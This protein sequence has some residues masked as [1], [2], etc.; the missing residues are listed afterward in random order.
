MHV[1]FIYPEIS[2]E[3]NS[4][5]SF[6]F[7][8][9]SLAACLKKAGHKVNLIH[10]T[11]T[12]EKQDFLLLLKQ[13]CPEG[14]IAFSCTTNDFPFVSRL[15]MWAK[16]AYDLPIICGGVHPTIVPEVAIIC[17][18]IDMICIGE[19]EA[20]LV[21]LCDHLDC[22]RQIFGI[23]N[24][25]LKKDGVIIKNPIRPML[26]ELDSL[27]F[28]DRGV[29][30]YE[31][32]E[33]MSERRLTIMASRG[34][35]YDC[36]YCCNH[37]IKERYPNKAKYVRFRSAENVIAEIEKGLR[38]YPGIERIFFHDDILPLDR[39]WFEEFMSLYKA[40]IGLP[41]GC[42]TRVNLVNRA[43]AKQLK[44]G[45]CIQVGMGIES[46]N[47][48]L[49]KTVLNRKLSREQINAA[50]SEC[51]RVGLRTYSFNMVG[52]PLESRRMVL[53]TIKLNA[54]VRPS[55]IQTS[56]FYPYP[57]TKLYH[58][59]LEKG[60]LRKEKEVDDYF[61]DSAIEL[62]TM[63]REEVIFVR[64]YFNLL[65]RIYKALIMLPN[66]IRKPLEKRFDQLLCW[67]SFPVRFLVTIKQRCHPRTVIRT[68]FPN[69]YFFVRPYVKKLQY[70]IR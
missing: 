42:N 63:T 39:Q 45:G 61:K 13:K 20:P 16:G 66:V 38:D 9:G 17:E 24:L 44:D 27:P 5:G 41:F 50:F 57:N 51:S 8:I 48:E 62:D 12:I 46:G 30:R 18:H 15:A 14:L 56:I 65:V 64:A 25:W 1:T 47:E 60:Y 54:E 58:L 6:H 35:P 26:E 32:L 36:S 55:K 40:R 4:R 69:L 28:P 59:C 43:V 3:V 29:F 7:G 34:C 31:D 33:E 49:R 68:K 19:G 21:E 22:G 37:L 52:L 53:E 23:R 11:R 2:S 67:R 70:R 10:L